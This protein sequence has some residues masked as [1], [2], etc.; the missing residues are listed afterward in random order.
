LISKPVSQ[1]SKTMKCNNEAN[2][3]LVRH[4]PNRYKVETDIS[5]KP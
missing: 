1:C 4:S 5:P 3:S 2:A